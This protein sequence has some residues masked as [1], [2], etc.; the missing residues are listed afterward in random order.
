MTRSTKTLSRT[1][2]ITLLAGT[3]LGCSLAPAAANAAD[4]PKS[5]G[6]LTVAL[7]RQAQ[8]VDPQQDNYGYGS[9]DG[10]QL[11]DSL[12]DQSF[13]EPTKIVPWLAE[14]WEVNKDASTYVFHLRKDV[15]FSD[16]K[17]LDAEVVKSNFETLAKI[18]GAAGGSYLKGITAIDIVDPYTLRITFSAPNVPFLSAT[19]T[20]ELGIVSPTTLAKTAEARC[21]EGVIGSGPFKIESLSYNEKAVLAKR[22]GYH[23]ASG[24]R[25]HQGEAYLDKIVYRIVP[26]ANVRTGALTSHQADIIQSVSESD[27]PNLE[28]SGFTVARIE[29]LG[30]AVNLL[31]NTSRGVLADKQV[32]RALLRGVN[33]K[34]VN[35]LA[36]SGYKL[37]ATSV[38][39]RKTPYYLDLSAE[40]A[41]DPDWSRKT[42]DDDGWKL[43]DDGI[44]VK[45]GK[46]LTITVS[47][48]SAPLNKAFLEVVQQEIRDIGF[49]LK[50]RPLTG[51]AFDEALLSGDY[52]LHRW[53]WSLGDVDVLRQIYSTKT[54]NRFRLP[55]DNPI[56]G[57]LDAQR[58]TT[59]TAERQKLT[60]DIQKTIIDEAYAIP[61]FDNVNLWASDKKVRDV[62]YGAAGS[63]GPN[64]ILYDAWLAD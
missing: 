24:L 34:E 57:P 29:Y 44:R 59:D 2:A 36:F 38:L 51:G 13:E 20:A 43:G 10:R 63:D 12:T 26:E 8:C 53:Q 30:T 56:D 61:I 4:T 9:H 64:Q 5:G 7:D 17:A 55:P 1:L 54:L 33:R 27:A 48:Y 28:S 60:A 37:P 15:T 52:D 6:T 31:I 46:P 47:F 35:D 40:L 45:D 3:A 49:D 23:W 18:P 19:S 14:S 21:H 16:G 62:F 42:L 25:K 11:V 32:R 41:Y 22:I 58:A 50:L 39:S